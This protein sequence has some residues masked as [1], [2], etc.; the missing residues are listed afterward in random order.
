M[1]NP[2]DPFPAVHKLREDNS[3]PIAPNTT[4]I[5][6]KLVPAKAGAGIQGV[7]RSAPPTGCGYWITYQLLCQAR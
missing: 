2:H 4:V 6:A 3:C 7:K 5:P 1:R